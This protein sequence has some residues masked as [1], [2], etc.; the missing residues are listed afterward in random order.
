MRKLIA[1]SFA[2]VFTAVALAGDWDLTAPT[3]LK[4]GLIKGYE[5]WHVVATHYRT[6]K[7][8]LRYI[9]GNKKAVEAYK[10]GAKK[11]PEGAILVKIGY[12]LKKNP[13][14]KA[15]VEPDAI[16]RVEFMIKDSKRFKDSAG[17]GFA[18]FVRDQKT[19]KY[20]VFGKSPK[21][22]AQCFSCHKLVKHKDFVFTDYVRR[23]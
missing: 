20:K 11:F 21:D 3:G 18:R 8:E 19:G 6:D 14:F 9:I 15:S 4:F 5:D 1:G 2:G 12:S 13:A 16:Q 17:W 7:N 10:K 22:Y 23:K